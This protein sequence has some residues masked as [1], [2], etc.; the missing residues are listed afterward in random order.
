VKF[1][2]P[3][4]DD[5]NLLDEMAALGRWD[6]GQTLS[7]G[8]RQSIAS[9]DPTPGQHYTPSDL[10]PHTTMTNLAGDTFEP[11]KVKSSF[12][13]GNEPTAPTTD[14]GGVAG[15]GIGAAGQMV[16][17][18]AQ[19][20]GNKYAMDRQMEASGASRALSEKLAKMQIAASQEDYLREQNLRALL[21]AL[22]A[23][24]GQQAISAGG[25]EVRRGAIDGMDD[26]L[27]K[28]MLKRG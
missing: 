7:A 8:Q 16:G 27:A 24:K 17:T 23:N 12:S 11:L 18:L 6:A 28:V 15:A 4:Q 1:R 10:A 2:P 19:V 22:G 3:T 13:V 14:W 25:R 21:W 9:G 26:L 5:Y 20:A